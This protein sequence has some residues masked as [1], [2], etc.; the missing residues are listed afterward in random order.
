MKS[1]NFWDVTSCILVKVLVLYAL[2]LL[3]FL[4]NPEGGGDMFF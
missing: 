3:G 1:S 4:F 2:F